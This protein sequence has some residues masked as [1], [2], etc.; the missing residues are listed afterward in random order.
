MTSS[1]PARARR[2]LPTIEA[3]YS[4]EGT[5]SEWL[6]RVLAAAG[7]DLGYGCGSYAFTCRIEQPA[8]VIGAYV[9]RALDPGF[10][11]FVA[12]LNRAAPSGV[13]DM[14]ARNSVLCGAFL[15]MAPP[16]VRTHFETVGPGAGFPDGFSLLAQDGEGYAIDVTAPSGRKMHAAPRVRGIWRRVGVHLAAAMRLRR[17]FAEA[18]A[19]RD[20]LF[21]P[22][23]K[24]AHVEGELEGDRSARASL[25][26]AVRNVER[27]RS[28]AQRAD[29]ERALALWR[30]LV[31]G[32]WSLVDHWEGE[33]RRYVAAY[34]NRPDVRDPRA[35]TPNERLV[36]RYASL[37]ASNKEIGFTL[38]L[39]TVAVA[40]AVAHLL[41]KLRCK[42]RG[43]LLAFADLTSGSLVR[44]PVGAEPAPDALAVLSL[45]HAVGE[46]AVA[47]LS[48][49]EREIA[50]AIVAGRT[51]AAIARGRGTSPN[52]VANQVRRLFEKLGVGS[53][54]ELARVLTSATP[55]GAR[56][57]AGGA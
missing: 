20:A 32:E 23:G 29:P 21:S 7:E 49:A 18:R 36:L 13:F 25:A 50:H 10:S 31:A 9:E 17:R 8:L 43:E 3:A 45:P 37:G 16:A 2:A 34:R 1:H 39:S 19:Q 4:L 28:G 56:P 35:L 26:A 11:A 40:S 12:D 55:P 44:V 42:R 57:E 41:A 54:M 27:A 5:D 38:G 47:G 14:L 46:A 22:S 30:G 53:R 51:N 48:A 15:E 33:G 24:L 52:T 6:G